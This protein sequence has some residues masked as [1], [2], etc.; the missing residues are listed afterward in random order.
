MESKLAG[1]KKQICSVYSVQ[2]SSA[3]ITI[4]QCIVTIYASIQDIVVYYNVAWYKVVQSCTL[5]SIQLHCVDLNIIY[6]TSQHKN[7]IILGSYFTRNY[8]LP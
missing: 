8:F 2:T 4:K 1:R 6:N 5:H 3:S 7:S